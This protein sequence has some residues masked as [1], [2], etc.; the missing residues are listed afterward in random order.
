MRYRYWLIFLLII[1]GLIFRLFI[2]QNG[3]FLFNQDNARDLVDVREM[4]VLKDFRLIG[5]NSS[6]DGLFQ[7]V[8]WYYILSVPFILS[9]GNPYSEI[10]LMILLWS[11]GA[12]YLFKLSFRWN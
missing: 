8:W 11:V 4:V 2:T 6:I 5:P 12:Y 10:I 3:S 7:G 1:I 9:Q